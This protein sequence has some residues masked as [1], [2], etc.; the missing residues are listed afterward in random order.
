MINCL[1]SEAFELSD[2]KLNDV[3]F[4]QQLPN[5]QF[6]DAIGHSQIVEPSQCANETSSCFDLT[7]TCEYTNEQ[8]DEGF[9]KC[10]TPQRGNF[11]MDED[12]ALKA[13]LKEFD[14]KM[15]IFMYYAI[16]FI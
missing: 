12:E 1:K 14:T 13:L 5:T 16:R 11:S 7:E 3:Q 2:N 6:R 8:V 4:A 9:L 10:T 15:I